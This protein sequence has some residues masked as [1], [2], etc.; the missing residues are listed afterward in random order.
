MA[1]RPGQ[2]TTY[3]G[4]TASSMTEMLDSIMPLIIL[5]MMMGMLMPMMK[6]IT[7]PAS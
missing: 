5:M 4:T 6:G 7:A 2:V 1:Y 3:G